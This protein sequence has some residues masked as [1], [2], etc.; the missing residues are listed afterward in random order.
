MEN[1]R[2]IALLSIFSKIYEKAF[3]IRLNSFLIK[4][5]LLTPRQYGFCKNKSTQ[6][7]VLSFYEKIL[8]NFDEKLL[9]AGI[10]FDLSRAFDTINHNL[11][12]KKLEIYG[13]RGLALE[14]DKVLLT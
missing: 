5:N 12:L 7:A 14:S 13:I 3:E 8:H 10:F 4:Y 11:L 6:D 2:P 9:S 1:F